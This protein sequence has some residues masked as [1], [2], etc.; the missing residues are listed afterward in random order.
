MGAA[1]FLMVEFLNVPYQTVIIAAI[2]PAAMHFFGVFCQVHFEAKRSGMRGL[3]AEELPTRVQVIREGWQTVVP[4]VVLLLVVFSGFTPYLA[5][6]WGI[7]GLPRR[8]RLA[9]SGGARS[10]SSPRSSPEL[11]PES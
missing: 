1:A 9:L 2:V 7:T 3:T 8:R 6:F 10:A 5:A 4:L 11:P